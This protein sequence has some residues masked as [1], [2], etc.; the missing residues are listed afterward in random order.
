MPLQMIGQRFAAVLAGR[1]VFSG[2]R[3]RLGLFRCGLANRLI[4]FEGQIELIL[5]LGTHTKPMTVLA[6]Q[7]VLQLLDHQGL[8]L[9][10]ICQ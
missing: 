3:L 1:F 10:L 5:A 8:R 9:D 4:F 2:R 7:L 6:R